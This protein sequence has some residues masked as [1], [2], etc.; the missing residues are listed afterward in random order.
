MPHGQRWLGIPPAPPSGS[1][2]VVLPRTCACLV[3]DLTSCSFT[4]RCGHVTG[5][6]KATSPTS[7]PVPGSCHLTWPSSTCAEAIPSPASSGPHPDLSLCPV[8]PSRHLSHL[9]GG[10]RAPLPLFTVQSPQ[11]IRWVKRVKSGHRGNV[12]S[13]LQCR[14]DVVTE[15]PDLPGKPC[16]SPKLLALSVNVR[17]RGRGSE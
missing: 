13:W 17:A 3:R 4:S 7:L 1:E 9:L 6:G 11:W 12:C 15:D 14:D 5:E 8:S 10:A 16:S 2:T